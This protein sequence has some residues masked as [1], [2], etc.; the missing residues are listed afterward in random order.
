M[1]LAYFHL[2][3]AGARLLADERTDFLPNSKA[4]F[5]NYADRHL[6]EDFKTEIMRLF[7]DPAE[8]ETMGGKF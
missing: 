7:P 2:H 1:E 8:W 5:L 4:Q 3:G 6:D